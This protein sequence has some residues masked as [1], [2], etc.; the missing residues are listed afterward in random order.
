M[1]VSTRG[2]Y[3][4]HVLIDLAE[5]SDKGYIPMKDIAKRQEISKKYMEHIMPILTKNNLIVGIHGQKGGYKLTKAPAEYTVL[6]ILKLT[7]GNLAPVACLSC[8]ALSCEHS[9]KC[10]TISMWQQFNKL[11]NEFFDG[12]TIYDLM[13][14]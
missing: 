10:R 8:E 14:K 6:E 13:I 5:N 3:A 9:S 4:L 12:I 2:R 1:M 7:E 11:T